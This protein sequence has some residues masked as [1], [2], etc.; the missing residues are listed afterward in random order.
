MQGQFRVGMLDLTLMK[1]AVEVLGGVD[2]IALTHLDKAAKGL[3]VCTEYNAPANTHDFYD[4]RGPLLVNRP[5]DY[6]YQ[7]RLTEA[8]NQ[9]G[10]INLYMSHRAWWEIIDSA[11]EVGELVVTSID[12]EGTGKG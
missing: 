9:L 5:A 7:C 2:E 3:T 4:A 1:Y 6:D 10:P 12:R 8:L 11:R